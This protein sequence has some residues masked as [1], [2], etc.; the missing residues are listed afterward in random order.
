MGAA[1]YAAEKSTPEA[2]ANDAAAESLA[3]PR[4]ERSRTSS[5][6]LPPSSLRVRP[7]L[8]LDAIG[9]MHEDDK[10]EAE[11]YEVVLRKRA[12]DYK[13]GQQCSK[14]TFWQVFQVKRG[15]QEVAVKRLRPWICQA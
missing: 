14:G 4:A 11:S 5:A 13:S 6:S 9:L 8:A 2:E 10:M 15:D 7:C 1:L 3:T 12:G